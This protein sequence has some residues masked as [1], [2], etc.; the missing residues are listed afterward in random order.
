MG[1]SYLGCLQIALERGFIASVFGGK[2]SL[3]D[4]F[5]KFEPKN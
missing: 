3:M 1:I 2:W 4:S 5:S